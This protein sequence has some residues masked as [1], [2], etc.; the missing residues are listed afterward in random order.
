MRALA[1][2]LLCSLLSGTAAGQTTFTV[3]NSGATAYLIGGQSNPALTL[4]RGQ[5]YTF[6]VNATGH[7][8]YIKTAPVTGTG[9]R[10]DSGVTGQGVTVGSLVF[11]VPMD[12]PN[13]LFYHCSIHSAMGD[14]LYIS[15]TL[16]APGPAPSGTLWLADAAP[17]PAREGTRFRFGLPHATSIAFSII[18]LR[19][20]E[21]R[22]LARG[23]WT[24]GDHTVRWDGRDDA[25]HRVPSG[26]YFY[27][28]RAGDRTL[29]RR[30][31]VTR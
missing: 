31:A 2:L 5:T 4:T 20:R 18:D 12:A 27:H 28:L 3:T 21:I 14:S 9:S 16:D 6:N 30:L 29:S 7:P 19:G 8:F 22:S 10:Y 26:L 13:T 15:P 23:E 11:V 25:G 24:A 1:A 17:N